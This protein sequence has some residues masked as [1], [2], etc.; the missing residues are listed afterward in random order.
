MPVHYDE[1]TTPRFKPTKVKPHDAKFQLPR[2][3]PDTHNFE[4]VVMALTRVY[5]P[6]RYI[7]KVFR[8]TLTYIDNR[9]LHPRDIYKLVP[10]DILHFF[11]ILYYM[12]YCKLP[13]KAD[14]WSDGDDIL[15]DHPVCRAFGMTHKK[16]NFIWRN[17]YLMTPREDVEDGQSEDE[18]EVYYEDEKEAHYV[19]RGDTNEDDFHFD[20]KVRS[21]VD[22][23]NDDN[24]KICIHPSHVGT[25]DEQMN[26]FK[27]RSEEKYKM[28]NKPITC[29]YNKWFSLVD[30][31]T[32]FL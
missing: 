25:I 2:P 5:L 10:R 7:M 17:V 24:K 14:Y 22:L 31:V 4:A 27:G 9:G 28:N 16:F 30:A 6:D 26:R 13:A 8:D 32:K 19:V 15:G 11:I 29:G 20:Q 3:R 18:G 23:T 1:G 12:G 21:M